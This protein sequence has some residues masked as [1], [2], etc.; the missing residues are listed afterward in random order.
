MNKL[1]KVSVLTTALLMTVLAI[2]P[3]V[4]AE[5]G[6][7][8][9]DMGVTV[10]VGDKG[11]AISPYIFGI[12][13]HGLD[14]SLKVKSVR[15]GGNRFTAYNWETNYSSAGSDW[16]HSSDDYLSSSS[17]PADCVQTLSKEATRGSIDY[18]LATAQMAGYVAA[19]KAGTVTEEEAAPSKRWNEVI[20]AKGS[21]LSLTPDL[22]DGKVYI[23]E[24][25]NYVVNKIGDSTTDTGIQGWSLDNEPG[26]WHHTHSRI[27]GDLVTADELLK[28]SI[29]TAKAIKSVDSNAEIFGPA[30]FGYTAFV[31]LSADDVG[32]DW[33]N[34]INADGK[35]DWFISYYLE[36]MK[37]AEEESGQRLLDVLDVHYYSEAKCPD[38][39]TRMCLSTTHPADHEKGVDELTQ[40][41]RTLIEKDYKENSWIG[42]WCQQNIPILT[43]MKESIDKYYPGTKLAVTE[44]D[45]GGGNSIAGAI[46]EVDALGTFANND[47]YY[48]TLWAD[49]V[50]Y[51]YSAINLFTN[52]DGEGSEFG[53]TLIESK[54]DDY[55]KST[56]YA[57]LQDGDKGEVTVILTNKDQKKSEN[58]VIDLK[59]ADTEYKN[60]AV[61]ILSGET[62]EIIHTVSYDE[63]KN[64]KLTVEIPPLAIAEVVISDDVNAYKPVVEVTK[65]TY[66]Y[67]D[68]TV[69]AGKKA[70]DY[71]ISFP[72]ALNGNKIVLDIALDGTQSASG[73]VDFS[74]K[75][76]GDDYWA[77]CNWAATTSGKVELDLMN[78]TGAMNITAGDEKDNTDEVLL[79]AL[80]EE[81]KKMKT[82]SF[83][84]W[85]VADENWDDSDHGK[86]T[87]KSA[88]L[89]KESSG[90]SGDTPV[91][92]EPAVTTPA[93]ET[94]EPEVTTPSESDSFI[95]GDVDGN[96]RV[97]VTDLSFLSLNL[98][99]EHDLSGDNEKAAD[100]DKDG[101][102]TLADL[103]RLRQFLS[104][105]I[106]TL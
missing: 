36:Q 81:I 8:S 17:E 52:Y 47:V 50:P 29:D 62:E 41:Y 13:E 87:L 25:V 57:S 68:G 90:E 61:Y 53:N 5:E 23:D 104:R 40:A 48:A 21:D 84:T 4:Y 71:S 34:N 15:Q 63:I 101:K 82:V 95:I 60:A 51:Q 78:L 42:E 19:D 93:P 28:K 18:K 45:F 38:C 99:G 43:K 31:Q 70:G 64:N 54:T 37:K 92:T 46:A 106:E 58:A 100:V 105:I 59:G 39:D 16:K 56:C 1:K 97:D 83:Q 72:E 6:T 35:Y 9:Y 14:K 7:A 73:C 44:Y 89:L 76:Q 3:A 33:K 11:K 75:Y 91:T 102:I 77:H 30:L 20:A 94:T 22:T 65:P 27:H 103:A 80:A 24:Y 26:L 2:N 98:I 96:G 49:D 10:N 85:Y 55:I 32:A 66:E 79:A 67:I 12:N 86:V 74:V 88:T 69:T